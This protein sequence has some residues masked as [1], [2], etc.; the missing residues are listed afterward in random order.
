M[1]NSIRAI[2]LKRRYI[3]LDCNTNPIRSERYS[4]LRLSLSLGSPKKR[5]Q[6]VGSSTLQPAC[7]AS[8][9]FCLITSTTLRFLGG[10]SLWK[11]LQSAISTLFAG[12]R[13]CFCARNVA[14]TLSCTTPECSLWPRMLMRITKP[15]PGM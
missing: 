12:K 7:I 14:K 10:I 5:K 8:T 15:M 1:T 3:F 4:Q 2:Q 6:R 9:H 11:R 13:P